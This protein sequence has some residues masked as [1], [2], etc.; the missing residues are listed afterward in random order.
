MTW[1]SLATAN[2]QP[3]SLSGDREPPVQAHEHRIAP[4]RLPHEQ[5]RG[6]LAGVGCPQRM[7]CQQ[8]HR[9][10]PD[11]QDVGDLG[12]TGAQ[13]V[14]PGQEGP[15]CGRCE[16]AVTGLP[17]DR[18][19]QL[20]VGPRP[21]RNGRVLGQGRSRPARSR[22]VDQAVAPRQRRPRTSHPILALG[23][24]RHSEVE[25]QLER[26]AR[27]RG[28]NGVASQLVGH[29]R[30][31]WLDRAPRQ[32]RWTNGSRGEQ[33]LACGIALE[34][35][36]RRWPDQPGDRHPSV[37]HEHLPAESD[38]GGSGTAEP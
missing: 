31:L 37:Q 34:V 1:L 11:S 33:P 21:D 18:A 22:L 4:A 3:L 10:L 14:D 8:P 24:D 7:A 26:C 5:R 9:A 12:E 19:D 35:S 17:F 6:E 23:I 29:R 32:A 15:P 38:L 36:S 27:P 20:D 30:D 13:L 28:Q 2:L 16:P 25:I